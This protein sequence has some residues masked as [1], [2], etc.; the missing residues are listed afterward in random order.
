MGGD[1]YCATKEGDWESPSLNATD[2]PHV[3]NERKTTGS[4]TWACPYTRS[5]PPCRQR[6]AQPLHR[7]NMRGDPFFFA[8]CSLRIILGFH[9]FSFVHFSMRGN[10]QPPSAC[11]MLN[12]GDRPEWKKT[13]HT[14]D[15]NWRASTTAV[16]IYVPC[17]VLRNLLLWR[18]DN[19][20]SLL[21]RSLS[22]GNH[23]YR[24][25]GRFCFYPP[26]HPYMLHHFV[27]VL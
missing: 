19:P 5:I 2:S 20:K 11:R 14:S 17:V 15:S 8:S 27:H 18:S 12:D 25:H 4:I 10:L 23:S 24:C 16:G 1:A 26:S 22:C 13:T 3:Q 21:Q 7:L 6:Q 9:S